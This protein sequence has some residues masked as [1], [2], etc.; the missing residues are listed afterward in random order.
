MPTDFCPMGQVWP[1]FDP[2]WIEPGTITGGGQTFYALVDPD[3]NC[4][5][6]VGFREPAVDFFMTLPEE[7]IPATQES[8]GGIKALYR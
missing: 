4:T 2:D 7:S 5:C 8:W 6:P 3:E 1:G